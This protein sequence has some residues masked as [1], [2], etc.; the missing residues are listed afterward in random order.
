MKRAFFLAG[1]VLMVAGCG[2]GGDGGEIRQSAIQSGGVREADGTVAYCGDFAIPEWPPL[3]FENN[4]W[5]KLDLTDWEQCILARDG[6]MGVEHGWRWRWP[7]SGEAYR[8][9]VKGYPEVHYGQK[10]SST[11]RLQRRMCRSAFRT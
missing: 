8:W 3:R 5:G 11:S 2:G 6:D 10:P 7:L 9:Q 1:L 4:V